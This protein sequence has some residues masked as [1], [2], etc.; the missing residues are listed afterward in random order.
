MKIA[1][2]QFDCPNLHFLVHYMF[3]T[4]SK[5]SHI[6]WT[7]DVCIVNGVFLD[8]WYCQ[9]KNNIFQSKYTYNDTFIIM[10]MI[11]L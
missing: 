5:V 4:C 3:K 8:G 2:T 11:L 9:N 10:L 6:F 1:Y 7:Y